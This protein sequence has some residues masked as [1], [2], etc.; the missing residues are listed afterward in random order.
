MVFLKIA[1]TDSKV[2]FWGFMGE[3]DQMDNWVLNQ[4]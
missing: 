2:S 4:K 3:F 1:A